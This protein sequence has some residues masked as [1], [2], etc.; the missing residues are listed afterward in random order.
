MTHTAPIRVFSFVLLAACGA[1]CQARPT[2]D[3]PHQL[4]FYDSNLPEVPR[5]EIPTSRSLPDAPSSVQPPTQAERFHTFVNEA[6]SPLTLGRLG[7]AGVGVFVGVNAGVT[8]ETGSGHVTP[9]MQHSFI[10]RYE[11][12][13]TQKDS[14]TFLDKYLYPSLKHDVRYQ[15]STSGSFMGRASDAASRI[16]ITRDDSGKGGADFGRSLHGLPPLLDAIHFGDSQQFWF[17]DGQRRG[18]QPLPRVS[19]WHTAN[20]KGLHAEVHVQDGSGHYQRSA[21]GGCPHSGKVKSPPLR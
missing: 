11:A 19:A 13:F 3:L 17:D 18:S 8:R 10:P 21:D 5:H 12:V 1:L 15:P 16:F 20:G 14:T 4:P 6:H 9:G 2:P 7:A